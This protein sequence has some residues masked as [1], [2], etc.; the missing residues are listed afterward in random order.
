MLSLS[1][2]VDTSQILILNL[3]ETKDKT[4]YKVN[5]YETEKFLAGTT[6]YL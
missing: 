1:F 4:Q 3:E 2:N 6:E 5:C